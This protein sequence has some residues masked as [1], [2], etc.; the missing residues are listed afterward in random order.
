MGPDSPAR[1]QKENPL[2]S[3]RHFFARGTL[4]DAQLENDIKA[5]IAATRGAQ[6]DL[7]QAGQH[8][9]AARMSEA[10]DE[11]LDELNAARNGT[12]TPKHA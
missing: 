4:S 7:Q 10:V 2:S 11:H 12:W 9:V 8:S 5:D 6:R 1:N 3:A